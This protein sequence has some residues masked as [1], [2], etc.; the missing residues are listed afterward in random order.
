MPHEH[1]AA[2]HGRR[3]DSAGDGAGAA[4]DQPRVAISGE[5]ALCGAGMHQAG[6]SSGQRAE[7]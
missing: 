2:L 7:A 5:A 4:A 6:Q 1:T 3:R